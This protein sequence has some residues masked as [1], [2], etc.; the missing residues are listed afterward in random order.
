LLSIDYIYIYIKIESLKSNF[1][2]KIKPDIFLKARGSEK[3]F[4]KLLSEEKNSVVLQLY[5]YLESKYMHETVFSYVKII[6]S[7]Y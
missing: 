7:E 6:K 3:H 5:T 1:I 2:L 4:L